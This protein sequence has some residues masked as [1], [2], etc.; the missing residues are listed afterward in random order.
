MF[1]K[2]KLLALAGAAGAATKYFTDPNQGAA[3]RANAQAKL[4][5]AVDGARNA[6]AGDEVTPRGPRT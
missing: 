5:G 2:L 4:R 1:K 6:A 3:R